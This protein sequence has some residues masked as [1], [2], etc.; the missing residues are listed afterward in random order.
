MDVG[1]FPQIHYYKT[2]IFPFTAL[3]AFSLAWQRCGQTVPERRLR[4]RITGDKITV[5]NLPDG[6]LSTQALKKKE[7]KRKLAVLHFCH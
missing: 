7:K 5:I 3:A 1:T 2:V 4:S 6:S